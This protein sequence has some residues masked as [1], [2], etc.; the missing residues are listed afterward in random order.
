MESIEANAQHSMEFQ[1]VRKQLSIC[2]SR[3]EKKMQSILCFTFFFHLCPYRNPL[4]WSIKDGNLSDATS[5][6]IPHGVVGTVAPSQTCAF[7]QNQLQFWRCSTSHQS[8]DEGQCGIVE[9]SLQTNMNINTMIYYILS[10]N[11]Q[12]S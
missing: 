5:I 9:I 8:S 4:E 12:Y 11:L 1:C 10:Q 3:L 7:C 2:G 6:P